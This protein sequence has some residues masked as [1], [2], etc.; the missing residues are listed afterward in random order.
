[1]YGDFISGGG[2]VRGVWSVRGLLVRGLGLWGG[3]RVRVFREFKHNSRH[4]VS[5]I[6]AVFY[7]S[8]NDFT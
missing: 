1:M 8:E 3:V 2:G 5:K 6:A 7:Y 4:L